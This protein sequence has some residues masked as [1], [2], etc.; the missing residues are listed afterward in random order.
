V[1]FRTLSDGQVEQFLEQGHLVL[2]GCF[3]RGQVEDWLELG[4]KRLGTDPRDPTT[5]KAGRV[6]QP[7]TDRV[8]VRE[9]APRVFDA[10]CDLCGGEER[11]EEP[12]WGDSFIWNF[13]SP[14]DRTWQTPEEQNR[15]WHKDGDFFRHFLDSPE[16]G[17]LVIVLYS[18]I[19]PQGGGTFLA[20]DS[21]PVVARFLAGRPEGVLPDAFPFR[22]MKQECHSFIEATGR[23]GDVLLIHPFALHTISKNVRGTARIITNPPVSLREPMQFQRADGDYSPVERAV[24]RGL[25]VESL[26]FAPGVPRE[27]V[28][29]E[30]ERVQAKMRA[31]EAARLAGVG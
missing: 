26:D 8:K 4:W 27:R 6:H 12:Y 14:D 20:A 15:G 30:R 24:L 23:L 2:R 29:P 3:E 21:V 10:M 22:E 25:G 18:D 17:L 9:F 11:I 19:E 28:V 13:G 5:W 7:A 1:E 16:Q 31:E